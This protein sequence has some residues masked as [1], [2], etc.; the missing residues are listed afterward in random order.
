LPKNLEITTS[1]GSPFNASAIDVATTEVTLGTNEEAL[2][3]IS[4][5]I[6]NYNLYFN[7]PVK[8]QIP[9]TASD[10][11]ISVQVKHHN[12][13]WGTTGLT[14]T[15]DTTCT[16]GVPATGSATATVS[17][18]IATIYTCQASDFAVYQ[19]TTPSSTSTPGGGVASI[20]SC[21]E[22]VYGAWGTCING[23]QYR[24]V[25]SKSPVN[26]N[27]TTEQQLD[28]Q[29]ICVI[30]DDEEETIDP[31]EEAPIVPRVDVK[32]VMDHERALVISVNNSL[33]NRLLGRILLQVEEKGQAW[34][35]EPL[36]KE[37]HFM[38]RPADAFDLMRR[39]G[40]G[41]SEANYNKFVAEGVPSRFAGRIFLRVEVNGEAY[42]VDP[43]D[44]EMHYL[45]RPAD[46]F[47]LMR[48]KA[49]GINNENIRQIPVG[50]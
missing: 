45:G 17:S 41:I 3:A 11:T 30:E 10:G 35:L 16:N 44:M 36:A 1:D 5:G 8:I 37:R 24:D 9:T 19:T 31:D 40:L 13:E 39:F 32:A 28:R 46:A 21:T 49:L 7:R 47:E 23:F 20:V 2:G 25:V 18:G 34:Y 38:G 50:N 15:W 12:G 14:N 33:V 4:F 48:N 27:L 26:C 22:V 43:V 42:Y 29:R 6:S